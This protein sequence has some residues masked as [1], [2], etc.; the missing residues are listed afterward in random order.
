MSLTS[1]QFGMVLVDKAG[2]PLTNISTFVDTTAQ[3]HHP[4]FLK[5]IGKPGSDVSA[6]RV[7]A[8]FSSTPPIALHYL[9]MKDPGLIAR[10]AD[11]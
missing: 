4:K 3:S 11:T 10:T 5:A 9:S 6:H 7:S 8:D 1:Y 2:H